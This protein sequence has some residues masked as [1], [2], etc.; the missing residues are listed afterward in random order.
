MTNWKAA[1]AVAA[2]IAGPAPA[3]AGDPVT[4]DEILSKVHE[5]AAYLAEAGDAGLATLDS[6]AS[7]F[8]WKDSYVFVYDCDADIIAAHPVAASRGATISALRGG[9]GGDFGNVLCAAA[10]IQG[11]SWAEYEWQRPVA[12]KAA[13]D[14]A[15]AG[16]H[17]RKVSYMLAV[18][19]R[20]WQVGAGMF[21][22]TMTLDQLN[23]LI[24]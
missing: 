10:K 14:L 17:V 18:E 9:D 12:A 15:Y 13:D 4:A 22:D 21:D 7:R 1:I 16:D 8:V 6:A 23:A 11:G 5:A 24:E 3:L 20:S 19:G 2:C